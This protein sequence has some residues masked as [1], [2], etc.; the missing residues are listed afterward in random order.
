[1]FKQLIAGL[2]VSTMGL[3]FLAPAVNA[4]EAEE[5]TMSPATIKLEG[6]A[7]KSTSGKFKVIN[8]GEVEF[9][10]KVYAAP[11]SVTGVE[12]SPDYNSVIQRNSISASVDISTK[13]GT[14][15]P[16]QEQEISYTVSIP[17]DAPPG[18]NYAVIFAETVP[19][20]GSGMILR[21]KRVGSVMRLTVDGDRIE[22]GRTESITV[23]WWSWKSTLEADIALENTGNVDLDASTGII[24]KSLLGRELHIEQRSNAVFPDFPRVISYEWGG[25]WRA[26]IYKVEVSSDIAGESAT[27]S[28]YIVLSPPW[29]V[30]VFA[31]FVLAGIMAYG[32]KQIRKADHK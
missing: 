32:I 10:F 21:T 19:D 17:A 13:S 20:D 22:Q 24:V 16:K 28:K 15:A 2:A 23:P 25:E 12:Y 26:G 11:Y 3:L 14:L 18:S 9:D 27:E 1:M 6:E 5:I 4:V 29:T 30:A 31:I 8:T 7:G